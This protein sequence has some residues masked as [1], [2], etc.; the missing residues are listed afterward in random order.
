MDLAWCMYLLWRL[1]KMRVVPG[2]RVEISR[3]RT[4]VFIWAKAKQAAK[5]VLT[6]DTSALDRVFSDSFDLHAGMV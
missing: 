6:W 1:A 3:K 2:I 4:A 5:A